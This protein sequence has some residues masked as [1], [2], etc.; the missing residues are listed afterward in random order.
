MFDRLDTN[1]DGVIDRGEFSEEM[2]ALVRQMRERR[3]GRRGAARRG[4]GSREFGPG[5]RGPS[6]GRGFRGP[7]RGFDGDRGPED[8]QRRGRFRDGFS[9]DRPRRQGPPRGKPRDQFKDSDDF[10][11][12]DLDASRPRNWAQRGFGRG[13]WRRGGGDGP[14]WMRR[15]QRSGSSYD[16]SRPQWRQ[17]R[18][19]WGW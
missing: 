18:D 4:Q 10:D 9:P 13:Y 3:G 17:R 12:W 8:F 14:P 5:G 11:N 16:S 1:S 2:P 15:G 7:R 6:R 19:N